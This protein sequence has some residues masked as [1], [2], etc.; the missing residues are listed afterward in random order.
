MSLKT[1]LVNL[2]GKLTGYYNYGK[3]NKVIF[4][5]KGKPIKRIF[6]PKGLTIML[7]GNNNEVTIELPL[8][9]EN[10]LV[11]LEGSNGVFNMK[12]SRHNIRASKFFIE[13]NSQINI[14]EDC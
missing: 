4:I 12:S 8:K 3:H 6:M 14:G 10:T 9:F 5:K 1:I 7:E 11:D 2:I 13:S